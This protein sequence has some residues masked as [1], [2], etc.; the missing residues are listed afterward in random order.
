MPSPPAQS[1]D[2][3]AGIQ[4]HPTLRPLPNAPMD[5]ETYDILDSYSNRDESDEEMAQERMY[6]DIEAAISLGGTNTR[7]IR[8]QGGDLLDGELHRYNSTA[9]TLNNAGRNQH[10]SG[11]S[12]VVTDQEPVYDFDDYESDAEAAAGIEAMRILDEQDAQRGVGTFGPFGSTRTSKSASRQESSDSDYGNVDMGLYGGGYD[13][14]LSYGGN[15]LAGL[16]LDHQSEMAD[17]SRPLPNVNEFRRS[18][19]HDPPAGLG[20]ISDYV[21]P[22]ESAIHPFPGPA[23]VDTSGT[24]GLQRPGSHNRKLSFDDGE[25]LGVMTPQRA[26]SRLSTRSGSDSPFKDDF[27]EMFYHPGMSSGSQRPLPTIPLS[28]N[29]TSSGGAYKDSYP[30]QISHGLDSTPGS[31]YS[32]QGSESYLPQLAINSNVQYVPRSTSLNS[33]STTPVTVPPV[34]SK[35][36]AEERQARQRLQKQ[37]MALRAGGAVEGF[38]SGTPQIALDLPVIPNGKRKKLHP[39]KLS[40]SDFKKCTEPWALSNIAAWLKEMGGGET[41]EGEA[42]L[43]QKTIAEALVALFTY[44]VPTMNTADAETLSDRT[45]KSLFDAEVLI[46]DEEWVKFGQGSICGV[47]WQL[48]GS[49]CYSP[50]LHEQEMSGRCYSHH[51]HRT[52][53]KIN[54][55]AQSLEPTRK[56]QDWVTF[57]NVKKEQ[58]AGVGKKEVERQN[59]LHEIV[60]SED[61]FMDQVNVLR[62]LYRDA[63]K[64]YQPPIIGPNKIQKFINTVFG[65]IEAIKRVNE[66]HLLAQLKYRQQEQGPWVVGFS[67][68]FREWIRKARIAYIEYAAGFPQATF[69]VRKEADK[70]LLFRQFLDQARAHELSGRLDWNTYLKAPIT[71]L[72]RYSLLL[73]T[74]HKNMVQDSE[75]KANLAIAIDEIKTVTLECDAKVDEMSK[76]VEM[77]EMGSKLI[78]RPGMERVELNLD[79]LGREL[80]FKG[81]LQRVG[82]NRFTWLETHAILFDH[83]LVLAKTVT[84]RD[85]SGSRKSERYD[86]SKLVSSTM[87]YQNS[88]ANRISSQSLCN[89]SFWRA[90]TMTQSS[91]L[92]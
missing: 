34:R 80:I 37:Q 14:H 10:G 5:D 83:Y 87:K 55:Q 91:S 19:N 13:A 1:L 70:N 6:Q 52:L 23:R 69:L 38:D 65:K 16:T 36:D 74:V 92:L 9:T 86:V 61:V 48:T 59:N 72:Q 58:F 20:G 47:M 33:H 44:K 79:H 63:L 82:A 43:R 57:Y 89:Y 28:E 2:A 15:D 4:R 64:T 54:L 75:E 60:T 40:S 12:T 67:D 30:D 49:G 42:D 41:G 29:L 56:S 71:R 22:G 39:S 66:D 8:P 78:L 24:G 68:I 31:L 32:S 46:H 17:Q 18:E 85:G 50:K 27:P 77:I 51:C 45:V 81:D 21:M 25:E 53:K 88:Q 76:K 90:Q 35:T 7:N 3:I 11:A 73:A 26:D 84:N 62:V